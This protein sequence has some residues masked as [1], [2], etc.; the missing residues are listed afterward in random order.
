MG[1]R[2][3]KNNPSWSSLDAAAEGEVAVAASAA[4]LVS[5]QEGQQQKHLHNATWDIL[6]FPGAH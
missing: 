1:P 3:I 5:T 6:Y 2:K 4:A